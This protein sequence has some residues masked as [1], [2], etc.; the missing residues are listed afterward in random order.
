[1]YKK[2]LRAT[3][4]LINSL[5]STRYIDVERSAKAYNFYAKEIMSGFNYS[6]FYNIGDVCWVEFG[7]NLTPEMSYLHMAVIMKR[8]DK[9]YYVLPITTYDVRNTLM[10]NA[11]HP[12]DN[13]IGNNS[14]FSMK[15][16]EYPFLTHDSVLKLAE[17]RPISIKRIKSRC[18]SVPS[19]SFD[20]IN[21][22]VF[23]RLFPSEDRRNNILLKENSLLYM[24]LELSNIPN[25]ISDKTEISVDAKYNPMI[26]ELVDNKLELKLTDSYG[27][28]EIKIISIKQIKQ[29]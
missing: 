19:N 15:S 11:Y 20:I 25:K 22:L 10:V 23:C 17:L 9:T 29:D 18:G 21:N 16:I 13:P 6:S 4:N 14:Y 2:M 24:K 5:S 12:I 1:M 8:Y 3:G 7:N 27:Q 26:V 28:S